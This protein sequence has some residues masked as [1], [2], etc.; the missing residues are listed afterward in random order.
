MVQ[1]LL[2]TCNKS[3]AQPHWPVYLIADRWQTAPLGLCVLRFCVL[4]LLNAHIAQ[5]WPSGVDK[6]RLEAG[7]KT[8]EVWWSDC[9]VFL[10]MVL[11]QTPYQKLPHLRYFPGTLGPSY[12][13]PLSVSGNCAFSNYHYH[14][15][16]YTV[17]LPTSLT[18]R[19]IR[20]SKNMNTTSA[21][22]Y[23]GWLRALCRCLSVWLAHAQPVIFLHSLGKY[24]T[25]FG[26][27]KT[28]QDCWR[29]LPFFRQSHKRWFRTGMSR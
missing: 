18:T 5:R 9:T 17:C 11:V 3:T 14:V 20:P 13:S 28:T 7:R 19:W 22:V 15:V 8:P 1:P 16:T 24:L 23:T 26:C 10:L 25:F 21:S 29:K 2:F 6:K 27:K 12:V 4:I